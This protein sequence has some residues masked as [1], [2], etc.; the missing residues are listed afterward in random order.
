MQEA[1]VFG[2]RKASLE[3]MRK[4]LT[5]AELKLWLT[6]THPPEY[7]TVQQSMMVLALLLSVRGAVEAVSA[8][9]LLGQTNGLGDS[10]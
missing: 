5:L 9:A 2:I 8:D 1:K 10:A 4:M 3:R 7:S 6:H